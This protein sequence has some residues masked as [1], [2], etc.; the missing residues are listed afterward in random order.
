MNSACTST[1]LIL[2]DWDA[3]LVALADLTWG[4]DTGLGALWR[5]L[6]LLLLPR[7]SHMG[8]SH[9]GAVSVAAYVWICTVA[10][11][12]YVL[13]LVWTWV[14]IDGRRVLAGTSGGSHHEL[15]GTGGLGTNGGPGLPLSADGLLALV[16]RTPQERKQLLHRRFTN[17]DKRIA[18]PGLQII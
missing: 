2:A 5:I 13:S 17:A 9:F 4:T 14:G 6:E 18:L 16:V 12:V 10:T 15:V 3:Q 8:S 1:D 11:R 7:L